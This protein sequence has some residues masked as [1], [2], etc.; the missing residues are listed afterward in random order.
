MGLEGI[1]PDN[2]FAARLASVAQAPGALKT[3][4][5]ALGRG[6]S[7]PDG[8]ASWTA[9]RFFRVRAMTAADRPPAPAGP[10]TLRRSLPLDILRALAVI[11][12]LGRHMIPSPSALSAPLG[13]VT[14]AWARGGW[15]GV[16]LFFV[17]SG[18]LVGGL[19]LAEYEKNSTIALGRFLI[20][21][22]LR[23]IPPLW[24]F[25]AVTVAFGYFYQLHLPVRNILTEFFFLQNYRAGIWG[26][27]WS[28][29][30]EAHFYVVV[31]FIVVLLAR[32][33]A[34]RGFAVL[35]LLSL[36][37]A[38][39]CLALRLILASR[40][41]FTVERFL[42]PSHLRLDAL[43]A[44]VLL[45]YWLHR[46]PDHFLQ[47]ATRWRYGLAGAGLLLLAPSFCLPLE[48]TAF[49]YTVGFT[50]NYLGAA[51]L[52]VAALGCNPRR[53]RFFSTLGRVGSQSYSIYLWNV[54]FVVWVVPPLLDLLHL[55]EYWLA[56]ATACI[57]G[58]IACG[59]IMARLTEYP[60]LVLRDRLFP[61]RSQTT[62]SRV[63][64]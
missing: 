30:V 23:I 6:K 37:L 56:Y 12:V 33:R 40:F 43:F 49:V 1:A 14:R 21:R 5:L 4:C 3:R 34:G 11:L 64:T 52:L 19:L 25:L 29:A 8:S 54:P 13:V 28:L 31:T 9:P 16:D 22:G 39:G 41:D 15:A 44:G 55:R 20:R 10:A 46:S 7:S 57:F 38:V 51:C 53:L 63:K 2:R 58:S 45:A 35:P 27:T 42:F 36:V 32:D 60:V 50:F 47:R 26:H 24:L 18:F 17:L 48:T 62:L 59:L 61:A